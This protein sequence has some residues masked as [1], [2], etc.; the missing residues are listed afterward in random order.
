MFSYRNDAQWQQPDDLFAWAIQRELKLRL[1]ASDFNRLQ[2]DQ[3]RCCSPDF[4]KHSDDKYA[5]IARMPADPLPPTEEEPTPAG[6]GMFYVLMLITP[7]ATSHL[8]DEHAKDQA[9]QVSHALVDCYHLNGTSPPIHEVNAKFGLNFPEIREVVEDA[10]DHHKR[11][12]VLDYLQFFCEFVHGEDGPFYVIHDSCDY[13]Y[14]RDDT[15]PADNAAAGQDDSEPESKESSPTANSTA[16][17]KI[18]WHMPLPPEPAKFTG[19]EGENYRIEACI[20][21]ARA[22]F[23]ARFRVQPSGMVEMLDDQPVAVDAIEIPEPLT[24]A[25]ISKFTALSPRDATME[26]IPD[27]D[28]RKPL[29]IDDFFAILRG[30]LAIATAYEDFLQGDQIVIQNRK[31]V[32][33]GHAF[34]HVKGRYLEAPH[35]DDDPGSDSD[36]KPDDP[37]WDPSPQPAQPQPQPQAQ[38]RPTLRVPA[39]RLYPTDRFNEAGDQDQL[40]PA[41]HPVRILIRGCTSKVPLRRQAENYPLSI[42]FERCR[43]HEIDLGGCKFQGYLDFHYCEIV[44]LNANYCVFQRQFMIYASIIGMTPDET[45]IDERARTLREEPADEDEPY[46]LGLFFGRG[47]GWINLT[48]SVI[49]GKTNFTGTQ[50]TYLYGRNVAFLDEVQASW[51]RFQTMKFDANDHTFRIPPSPSSEHRRQV[52]LNLQVGIAGSFVCGGTHCQSFEVDGLF[53]GDSLVVWESSF[54]K[55]SLGPQRNQDD[56]NETADTRI[57]G[58]VSIS[59]T[60][61]EYAVQFTSVII[62]EADYRRLSGHSKAFE[63]AQGNNRVEGY[64]L[65]YDGKIAISDVTIGGDLAIIGI[66]PNE[67]RRLPSRT[68]RDAQARPKL[69]VQLEGLKVGGDLDLRGMHTDGEIHIENA[70]VN[71]HLRAGLDS[72]LEGIADPRWNDQMEPDQRWWLTPDKAAIIV[73]QSRISCGAFRLRNSEIRGDARLDGV[74]VGMH[75]QPAV[76]V[77]RFGRVEII[78]SRI[79]GD[80][81]FILEGSDQNWLCDIHDTQPNSHTRRTSVIRHLGKNVLGHAHIAAGLDL[82]GSSCAHLLISG[83]CFRYIARHDVHAR[84]IRNDPINA[85]SL[86]NFTTERFELVHSPILRPSNLQA[87]KVEWWQFADLKRQRPCPRN[88]DTKQ[89]QRPESRYATIREIDLLIKLLESDPDHPRDIYLSIERSLLSQ[90]KIDDAEKIRKQLWADAMDRTGSTEPISDRDEHAQ[91]TWRAPKW[92][93]VNGF[94]WLAGTYG[95]GSS[96]S[97]LWPVVFWIGLSLTMLLSLGVS[98]TLGFSPDWQL[99]LEPSLAHAEAYGQSAPTPLE[100]NIAKPSWMD[101][102]LV[103]ARHCLPAIILMTAEDY[104]PSTQSLSFLGI[105]YTTNSLFDFATIFA[106]FLWLNALTAVTFRILRLAGTRGG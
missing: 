84:L 65:H 93:V 48:N 70:I 89:P 30:D 12:L 11:E 6:A 67:H 44:R 71:G 100:V 10:E 91:P 27:D 81:S 85:V 3:A 78:L 1:D 68:R 18:N 73:E 53:F 83:A 8:R 17:Y 77:Q 32:T 58:A 25:R 74:E 87:L 49:N 23:L 92:T 57:I 79:G 103:S 75:G 105:P 101:Y 21:Y 50:L 2:F 4:Y 43:F 104:R 102:F 9:S 69:G 37:A 82:T 31:I 96:W 15:P 33:D 88:P 26:P 39:D 16:G 22:A 66:A 28:T 86:Q 54:E 106:W 99:Y 24:L 52:H 64:K 36:P 19:T 46:T 55:F 62:D 94:R 90:G 42:T 13:I 80:L 61:F 35:P 41:P 59:K 97:L 20:S 40:N 29:H 95:Y 60:R 34:S 51:C 47:D 72:V 56:P 14:V 76:A 38:A 98:H 7:E 63:Q 45:P 5:V